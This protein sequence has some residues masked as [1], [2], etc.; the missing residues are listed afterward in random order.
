M[1]ECGMTWQ[2]KKMSGEAGDETWREFATV[3]LAAKD[4]TTDKPAR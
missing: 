3:C 4:A 1:H 2:G